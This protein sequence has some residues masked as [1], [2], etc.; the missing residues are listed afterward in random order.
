M[1]KK[2]L[3]ALAVTGLMVTGASADDYDDAREDVREAWQEYQ[4]ELRDDPYDDDVCD[5]YRDYQQAL[6]RLNRYRF[7]GR[8]NG[9]AIYTPNVYTPTIQSSRV[10]VQPTYV[11]T[12]RTNVRTRY[13][14]QPYYVTGYYYHR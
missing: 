4:E 12:I 2:M 1:I 6:R 10:Y 13:F 8:V 5:A 7:R 3:T 9:P 11:P 14:A